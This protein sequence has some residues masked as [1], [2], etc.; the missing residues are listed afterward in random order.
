MF[1]GQKERRS[2]I[3]D[4][5]SLKRH[6]SKNNVPWNYP[7][8]CGYH[9]KKARDEMRKEFRKEIEKFTK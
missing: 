6:V 9:L 5:D 4:G 1:P 8:C 3:I 2:A 7:F